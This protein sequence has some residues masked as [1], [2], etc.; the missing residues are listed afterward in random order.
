MDACGSEA[1]AALLSIF[2]LSLY[3]RAPCEPPNF[4]ESSL[5]IS[6]S[7]QGFSNSLGIMAM[8]AVVL[9]PYCR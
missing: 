2:I 3:Y 7:W 8:I 1:N 4:N 6:A 9:T 5:Y